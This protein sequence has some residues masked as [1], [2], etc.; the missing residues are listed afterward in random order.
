MQGNLLE[1]RQQ[2]F[3]KAKESTDKAQSKLKEQYDA[4][5][6]NETFAIG[7]QV[8]V[9]NTEDKQRKGGIK[10]GQGLRSSVSLLVRVCMKCATR[11]EKL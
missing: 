11:K 7:T 5:H 9:E 2:V 3:S 8:L 6:S 10:Y 1:R 4:K